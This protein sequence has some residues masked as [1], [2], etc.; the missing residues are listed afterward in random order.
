[1][2]L[3]KASLKSLLYRKLNSFLSIILL[4]FSL[5]LIMLISNAKPQF[6]ANFTKNIKGIDLVVGAKGSPLQIILSSI[7]QIDAPTGNISYPEFSKLAKHPQVKKAIP[8]SFGDNF[9]SFRIVGTTWDYAEHYQAELQVGKA[10][11]QALE[12][13]IGWE[14]AQQTGLK[15]GDT[16]EGNHGTQEE[17]GEHHHH[18]PF[19]ITGILK[20]TGTV[21]D[22]IILCSYPSFWLIHHT[23]KDQQEITAGILT[24]KSAMAAFSLPRMIN[25]NSSLQAAMPAIEINRLFS[26]AAQ[27]LQFLE[28]LAYLLI[29][30]SVLSVFIALFQNLKDEEPQMAF[31]RAIGAPR[32]KILA[33]VLYKSLWIGGLSFLVSLL[34]QAAAL[35]LISAWFVPAYS[36]DILAASFNLNNLWLL[37]ITLGISLAAALLPAWHAYRINISKTLADA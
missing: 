23:P 16:F 12:A 2:N 31:L 6:E 33:L 25:K 32:W 36:F 27:G 24:Y 11:D 21:L 34:L 20:P 35:A 10:F 17:G 8:L 9:Q 28:A 7:Y 18:H 3:I 5:G 4:S 1:M 22:Q 29:A 15:V 37:G 14:V 26:L 19:T 13:V 30:V